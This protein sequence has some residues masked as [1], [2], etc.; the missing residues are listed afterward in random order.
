[1]SAHRYR[2]RPIAVEAM[3]FLGTNYEAVAEWLG[4]AV[5]DGIG[6]VGPKAVFF[7]GRGGNTKRANPTDYI[8]RE[9]SLRGGWVVHDV[10]DRQ[11]FEALF[12]SDAASSFNEQVR[13]LIDTLQAA[14]PSDTYDVLQIADLLALITPSPAGDTKEVEA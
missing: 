8:V 13:N 1:M 2:K 5:A 3:L 11:T 10:Y 7:R 14:P 12:E 6:A 9:S 4:S